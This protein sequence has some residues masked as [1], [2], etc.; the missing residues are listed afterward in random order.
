M[1]GDAIHRD[2]KYRGGTGLLGAR[3][4]VNEFS[5]GHVKLKSL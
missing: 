1:D 2:K 4:A 3:V 5:L